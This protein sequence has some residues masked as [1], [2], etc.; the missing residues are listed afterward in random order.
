[1]KIRPAPVK[2][3]Q[4]IGMA[5]PSDRPC[6][7][8]NDGGEVPRSRRASVNPMASL[9][10]WMAIIDVPIRAVNQGALDANG[11]TH[12]GKMR[13][14]FLRAAEHGILLSEP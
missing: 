10:T 2:T 11:R 5:E 9:G 1:L 12:D 14:E 13:R 6:S 3:M 8:E 4:Q 7:G